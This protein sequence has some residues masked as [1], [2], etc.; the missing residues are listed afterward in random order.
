M[1]IINILKKGLRFVFDSDYRFPI[2]ASYLLLHS[3]PTG[4]IL[5]FFSSGRITASMPPLAMANA[6]C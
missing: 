4:R 5:R 3:L 1:D 2:L 6:M